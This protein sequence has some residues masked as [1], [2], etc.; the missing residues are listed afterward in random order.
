MTKEAKKEDKFIGETAEE[1]TS[2]LSKTI[3]SAKDIIR[4]KFDI[5][6]IVESA[7]KKGKEDETLYGGRIVSE[8]SKEVSMKLGKQ[9]S[10]KRL[11][12]CARVYK[13]FNGKISKVWELDKQLTFP[14]TFSFLIKSCSPRAVTEENALEENE[15]KVMANAKLQKWENTMMEIEEDSGAVERAADAVGAMKTVQSH[16]PKIMQT[17][18]KMLLM[19]IDKLLGKIEIFLDRIEIKECLTDAE[20]QRIDNIIGRLMKLSALKSP[21]KTTTHCTEKE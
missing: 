5:G 8:L 11:Y 13:A 2:L 18:T 3:A 20:V 7:I 1:I 10:E 12:D 21:S 9:I 16:S 19:K 6:K 15:I 4:H 14:L 17:A